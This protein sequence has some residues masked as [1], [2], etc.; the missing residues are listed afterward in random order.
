MNAGRVAALLILAG[1][2]SGCLLSVVGADSAPYP[3][4][5]SKRSAGSA[6]K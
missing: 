3:K 2:L 6:H 5:S 1:S 4:Q